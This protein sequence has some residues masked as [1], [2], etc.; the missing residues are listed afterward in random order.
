MLKAIYNYL[1]QEAQHDDKEDFIRN[2][3]ANI[4]GRHEMVTRK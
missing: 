3:V 1:K 2:I 4:M